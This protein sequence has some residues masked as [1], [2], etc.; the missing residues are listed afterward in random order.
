[1][2][3]PKTSLYTGRISTE[4]VQVPRQPASRKSDA[5]FANLM[6]VRGALDKES[7]ASTPAGLR[8]AREFGPDLRPGLRQD[9]RPE[10]RSELRSEYRSALRPS[11]E[12]E[13]A[14]SA[15]TDRQK[16]DEMSAQLAAVQGNAPSPYVLGGRAA[17][18]A[19]QARYAVNANPVTSAAPAAT[20]AARQAVGEARAKAVSN[21]QGLLG[22]GPETSLGGLIGST[23]KQSRAILNGD[24]SAL[25]GLS[26]GRPR[27]S[28][29][30]LTDMSRGIPLD[31]DQRIRT[32]PRST[33]GLALAQTQ[34]AKRT[35]RRTAP[36]LDAEVGKLAAQ[37]ESG[38]D[39]IAAIGYDRNG[40]TS[41]GKYQIA[42]RPG[43]MDLFMDF[44]EVEAPDLA[45]RLAT[46]G[47]ANTGSRNGAMPEVWKSIASENPAR[48]EELQERFIHESHY[49]PAFTSIRRSGYQPERFSAAMKEVLFSTA[50]QHGPAGATRIFARAAENLGLSPDNQRAQEP[51]LIREIYAI[52]ADQFGS[53]TPQI[54][55]A[56][57]SRMERE[58][59][60]AEAMIRQQAV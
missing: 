9:T 17:N 20:E 37:F 36:M 14:T 30:A 29:I 49:E 44:L 25:A 23:V 24:L 16:A 40:G 54:Q 2:S 43:T 50:V 8:N 60:L 46:S 56:A 5:D 7:T 52:R 55:L 35:A 21:L 1:M 34:A 45:E 48:F 6:E 13:P 4:S 10:V 26:R 58:S 41:Y 19:L 39:G 32:Q 47:P 28:G 51:Q 27:Q 59:R 3:T 22:S 31:P 42:S 33:S 12:P 38:K 53:S 18:M 15:A 57:R 11:A